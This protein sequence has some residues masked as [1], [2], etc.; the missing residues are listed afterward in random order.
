MTL[1]VHSP[2]S[3]RWAKVLVFAPAG[4]G[5]TVLLGTAQEDDR[6][7][8][9][10][11]IDWEA[12][13]EVLEGLDIDVFSIRSWK[14]ADQILELLEAGDVVKMKDG[15]GKSRKIDFGEYQS[16]GI[17]SVSE[18]NRWAQLERLRLKGK[19]RKDPDL[20]EMQDYNVTGVQL[21]RVLRR[22]RDLEMHVFFSSHAKLADDPRLGR[23]TLPDLTGQLAEEVAGLVSTSGYL[24]LSEDEDGEPERLLLLHSWPKFRTKVRTPWNQQAPSEIV[25]PD[26]TEILDVL[27]YR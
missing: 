15:N 24:A 25:N 20:I 4:H 10:C 8:P 27:G 6:T 2:A 17:D 19:S 12:G 21:R 7:Y 26:V 5:K 13:S 23:V 16:L 14:D 22:I 3:L 18:M 1:Q 9:M 11:F